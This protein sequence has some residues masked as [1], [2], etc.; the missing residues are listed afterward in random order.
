MKDRELVLT[1]RVGDTWGGE[2][3][4]TP[5]R[6]SLIDEKDLGCFLLK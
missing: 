6:T 2:G 4:R 3:E 5:K 1:D